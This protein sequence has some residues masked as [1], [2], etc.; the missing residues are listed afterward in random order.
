M[1]SLITVTASLPFCKRKALGT[2]LLI[3]TYI[4]G[5]GCQYNVDLGS[6]SG[7]EGLGRGRGRLLFSSN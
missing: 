7:G 3:I 4:I 2:K 1:D 5:L 6:G